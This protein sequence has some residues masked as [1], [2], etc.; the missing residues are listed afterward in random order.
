MYLNTYLITLIKFCCSLKVFLSV[1]VLVCI[2]MLANVWDVR[3]SAPVRNHIHSLAFVKAATAAVEAATTPPPYR[4]HHLRHRHHYSYI[5][6]THTQQQQHSNT[7]ERASK[8]ALTHIQRLHI[9]PTSHT[10]RSVLETYVHF[11]NWNSIQCSKA[12]GI[13]YIRHVCIPIKLLLYIVNWRVLYWAHTHRTLIRS[14]A[15][16]YLLDVF[17]GSIQK[18]GNVRADNEQKTKGMAS[19]WRGVRATATKAKRNRQRWVRVH[20][21]NWI[22]I[23]KTKNKNVAKHFGSIYI[24]K[25]NCVIVN[26]IGILE[27]CKME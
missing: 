12:H 2:Y 23:N 22:G 21:P 18:P 1:C 27:I 10:E 6:R 9:Q 26:Y 17:Y 25:T 4:H 19:G 13:S 15:R 8:Q 20:T 7:S 3:C 16:L 11:E 14:L 24:R 5:F